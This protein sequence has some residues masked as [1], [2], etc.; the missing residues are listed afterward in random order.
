MALI[1]NME[2]K[3]FFS[4]NINFITYFIE[5]NIRKTLIEACSKNQFQLAKINFWKLQIR[6]PKISTHS[7]KSFFWVLRKKLSALQLALKK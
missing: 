5:I 7:A 6:E 4:S 2:P 3:F 1:L